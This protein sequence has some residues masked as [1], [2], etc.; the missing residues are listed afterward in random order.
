ME[1]V[2]FYFAANARSTFLLGRKFC[3]LFEGYSAGEILFFVSVVRNWFI[4]LSSFPFLPPPKRRVV[5]SGSNGAL[6]VIF[7]GC[8][9]DH[10]KSVQFSRY[11][12]NGPRKFVTRKA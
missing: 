11:M 7:C 10:R 5:L 4:P 1:A 6:P 12:Y 3:A 9:V 8:I 2:A